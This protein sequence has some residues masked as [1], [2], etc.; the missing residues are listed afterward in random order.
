MVSPT[1]AMMMDT[2]QAFIDRC[3]AY[4]LWEYLPKIRKSVEGMD[5][6]DLW[7]RPN[8]QSNSVGNLLLHLAGNVR[9]WVVSGIGGEDDIRQRQEE[10]DRKGGLSGV[11]LLS[12][13]EST[14]RDVDRVLSVLSPRR[15]DERSVIQGMETSVFEALFHVVEHFSMHT[16]QI[17]YLAKLKTGEDLGFY[18][19]SDGV[20]EAQW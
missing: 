11:E 12:H 1:G 10:F 7:W 13:L 6:E 3:R 2:G 9:Q 19:V 4:L 15:L 20:A 16:G 18:R 17:I 14:L 8:A 5:P